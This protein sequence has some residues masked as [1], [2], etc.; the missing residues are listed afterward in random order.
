[1]K[2]EKLN[3]VSFVCFLT[4]SICFYISAIFSFMNKT[5]DVIIG[6]I[7]NYVRI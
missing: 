6:V 1:M 5:T 7:N 2:K 4:A 3:K